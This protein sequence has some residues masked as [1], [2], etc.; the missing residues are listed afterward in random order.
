MK[1]T[2]N[3]FQIL[4]FLFFSLSY[5]ALI[6]LYFIYSGSDTI[7]FVPGTLVFGLAG[8]WLGGYVYTHHSSS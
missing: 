6:N 7:T 1:I 2:K 5:L 8:Y 3:K 4:C